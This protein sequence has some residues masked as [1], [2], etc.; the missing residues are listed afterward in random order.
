MFELVRKIRRSVVR[1]IVGPVFASPLIVHWSVHKAMTGYYTT[2]MLELQKLTG[3][4]F[5]AF[6]ADTRGVTVAFGQ[7]QRV[8]SSVI[9]LSDLLDQRVPDN[10]DFLG[11][12][13]LR[14]PRDLVV[15]GY[16]YHLKTTELWAN[17][18]DYDWGAIGQEP[19]YRNRFVDLPSSWQG[20][21]YQNVLKDLTTSDGLM[22]EMAR[23]SPVIRSMAF[24]NFDDDKVMSV[25]YEEIIGD[26]RAAFTKIFDHYGLLPKFKD[27]ALTI[28][29]R[30]S[31]A[32]QAKTNKHIRSSYAGEWR[33]VFDASHK[34][35]FL[36]EFRDSLRA[37]GYPEV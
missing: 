9:L 27:R 28:V 31:A 15:S 6:Y 17:Q 13:T 2:V 18:R 30:L 25:S 8:E 10:T 14:D 1:G 20:R 33:S 5:H 21:S 29:E 22:L 36:A 16:F 3:L 37:T 26:E 4:C 23:I 11:T 24:F 12:A 35:Y 7:S 19:I 32:K 34:E